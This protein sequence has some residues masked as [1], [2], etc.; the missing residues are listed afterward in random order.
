MRNPP[1][2]G[3]RRE[4]DD[5]VDTSRIS[6]MS[7]MK[8]RSWSGSGSSYNSDYEDED[9]DEDD[10]EMDEDEKPTKGNCLSHSRLFNVRC[11]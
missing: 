2:F 11:I 7:R 1:T 5:E 3:L 4:K 8:Q 9:E 10:V 6:R